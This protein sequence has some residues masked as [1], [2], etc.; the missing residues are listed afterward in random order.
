MCVQSQCLLGSWHPMAH[1]AFEMRQHIEE[2]ERTSGVSIPSF[3]PLGSAL[4]SSLN[5]CGAELQSR[6]PLT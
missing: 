5:G 6:V 3:E 4:P 2:A 1:L